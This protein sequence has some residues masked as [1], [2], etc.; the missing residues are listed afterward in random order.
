MPFIIGFGKITGQLNIYGFYEVRILKYYRLWSLCYHLLQLVPFLVLWYFMVSYLQIPA[1]VPVN[2]KF[3]LMCE[4]LLLNPRF[5]VLMLVI[6]YA[7]EYM[8]YVTD[9]FICD[10]CFGKELDDYLTRNGYDFNDDDD[11]F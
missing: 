1:E 5:S 2:A 4:Y 10:C 6:L 11:D 7:L 9:G 8:L 3:T